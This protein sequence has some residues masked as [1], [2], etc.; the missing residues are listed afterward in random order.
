ML[1][2]LEIR[3]F[4]LIDK[5]VIKPG[6]GF[7]VLTGETGAGKSI[8]INALELLSGEKGSVRSVG[9]STDKL[10]V[11][12]KFSVKAQSKS[13]KAAFQLIDKW[14]IERSDDSSLNIRREITKEG[15]SR[16][17]INLKPVRVSQLKELGRFLIDI[18]GQHENQSL[19][20]SANHIVYY[21][22]YAGCEELKDEYKKERERLQ[23]ISARYNS[24]LEN[25]MALERERGM[26]EYAVDE[27]EKADPKLNE[28]DELKNEL[29]ALNN[30]EQIEENLS[31]VYKEL[32][33]SENGIISK[34]GKIQK[35]L[36]EIGEYDKRLREA[37]SMIEEIEYRSQDLSE[38]ISSVRSESSYDPKRIEEVNERLFTLSSLKKKYGGTLKEVIDYKN[39]AKEK[40]KII[41]FSDEDIS[42]LKEEIDSVRISLSEKAAE[43]SRIRHAAKG[44]FVEAV[45]QELVKLGMKEASFDVE[46]IPDESSEGE[47]E[48]DGTTYNAGSDG[49]DKLEF[50]IAAN[51][52]SIFGPLKKIASGG[53]ISR[54][55][56]AMKNVMINAQSAGSM[57]F[58]EID[59]GIGGRVAEVIGEK[60]KT[61]AAQ[62]QV[63]VITHLAQIAAHASQQFRVR[64]YEE[65]GISLTSI[66]KLDNKTR[67]EE[68]ARMLGGKHI[69]E[70][71][72]KHAEE[73]LYLA[74]EQSLF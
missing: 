49:I 59:T 55:M 40:L 39:E 63:I 22:S 34:A 5:L 56:L 20:H 62:R 52:G 21:D 10:V 28:E 47:L 38:M 36:D 24:I 57:V 12:G 15:K 25:K 50:L 73:M 68:I 46:I 13:A 27:I 65:N 6:K 67:V 26:L 72:I 64:K 3:N 51:K 7:N 42:G 44:A 14:G 2:S 31:A 58:D 8:I 70:T 71:T 16:S 74:H 29:A 69:T 33:G 45:T 17:Y 60:I 35:A 61:I 54:I 18:H 32:N 4:V 1:Q 11:V 23:K 48:I 53:E 41:S 9:N 43:L 37:A 66:E 19:F 30:Y